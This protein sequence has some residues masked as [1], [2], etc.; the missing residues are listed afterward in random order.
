[1]RLCN[2]SLLTLNR[3][4]LTKIL[5]YYSPRDTSISLITYKLKVILMINKHSCKQLFVRCIH[6]THY[7]LISLFMMHPRTEGSNVLHDGSIAF[8]IP[9][10]DHIWEQL[11]QS[12]EVDISV[13]SQPMSSDSSDQRAS[14]STITST[15]GAE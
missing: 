3:I 5:V 7:L 8:D 12:K 14:G 11:S 15:T 1:M 4:K 9:L 10:P 2:K 6:Y 13:P